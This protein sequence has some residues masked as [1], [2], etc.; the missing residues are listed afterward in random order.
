MMSE[1]TLLGKK[2]N[3]VN[4]ICIGS[5]TVPIKS[6]DATG[7][8]LDKSL[9]YQILKKQNSIEPMQ[10]E[11][12]NLA[13]ELRTKAADK[14][15]NDNELDQDPVFLS[16]LRSSILNIPAFSNESRYAT[17]DGQALKE[18]S[19]TIVTTHLLNNNPSEFDTIKTI[20]SINDVRTYTPGQK[21]KLRKLYSDYIT[22]GSKDNYLDSAFL[23]VLPKIKDISSF[24]N[25]LKCAL[26][27]GNNLHQYPEHIELTPGDWL[28][29]VYNGVNHYDA[30]DMSVEGRTVVSQIIAQEKKKLLDEFLEKLRRVRD[31]ISGHLDPT[32]PQTI[33]NELL[34]TIQHQYPKAF[35]AFAGLVYDYD[36]KAWEDNGRTGDEPGAKALQYNG[37]NY[38]QEKYGEW[39]INSCTPEDLKDTLATSTNEEINTK[40]LSI[41]D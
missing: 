17:P 38:S 21:R 33:K 41:P 9:A 20:L 5:F 19:K 35:K 11:L 12:T 36:H 27:N 3:Y 25:G 37:V 7:R 4:S 10:I 39:R 34:T 31:S 22:H 23:Y 32:S 8:C 18:G 2:E 16:S 15:E 29:V 24:P 14:I 13:N 28:Y 6:I 1:L 26:F 30:V 40:I